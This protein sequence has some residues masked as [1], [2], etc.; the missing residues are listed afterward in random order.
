MINCNPSACYV[1]ALESA[2]CSLY[3][4]SKIL[5]PFLIGFILGLLSKLKRGKK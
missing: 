4:L 1:T 5:L 3:F 2:L